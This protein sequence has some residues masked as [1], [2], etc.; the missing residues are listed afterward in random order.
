MIASLVFAD[1]KYE[2]LGVKD[3]SDYQGLQISESEL[4]RNFNKCLFL[5]MTQ[6]CFITVGG[7]IMI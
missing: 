5:F 4:A 1:D 3:W 6:I 7:Y 2:I